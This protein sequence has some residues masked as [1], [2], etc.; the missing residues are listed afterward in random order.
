MLLYGVDGPELSAPN[1]K[2]LLRHGR[3]FS[4]P[5]G[6]NP[7]CPRQFRASPDLAAKRRPRGEKR[8]KNSDSFVSHSQVLYHALRNH[9]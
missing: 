8:Q 7:E 2:K 5:R 3:A 4:S 1:E 6:R 9:V